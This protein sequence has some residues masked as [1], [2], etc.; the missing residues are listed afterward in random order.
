MSNLSRR[1]KRKLL[2]E[3]LMK[4]PLTEEIIQF[5]FRPAHDLGP[6]FRRAHDVLSADEGSGWVSAPGFGDGGYNDDDLDDAKKDDDDEIEWVY[7]GCNEAAD[8]SADAEKYA[9]EASKAANASSEAAKASSKAA[10][11]SA[12]A[13]KKAVKASG[14]AATATA[15]AVLRAKMYFYP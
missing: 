7:E 11:A 15:D 4:L 1:K 9:E 13:N 6:R 3:E 10:K 5:R 8:L 2:C 12:K 14:E